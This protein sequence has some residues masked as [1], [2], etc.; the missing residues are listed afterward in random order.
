MSSR[1]N[2]G[3]SEMLFRRKRSFGAEPMRNCIGG[4]RNRAVAEIGRGLGAAP[5]GKVSAKKFRSQ[6]ITS[7]SDCG[8]ARAETQ[9]RGVH[10]GSGMRPSRAKG[11]TASDELGQPSVSITKAEKLPACR[12]RRRI[13]T[14]SGRSPLKEGV[15]FLL[16]RRQPLEL[17]PL[18]QLWTRRPRL[19]NRKRSS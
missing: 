15:F 8:A 18:L 16:E 4:R 1:E 7:Y 13:N 9:H 2:A 14:A 5:R 12:W 17:R 3:A 6:F 10:R 11:L 19:R